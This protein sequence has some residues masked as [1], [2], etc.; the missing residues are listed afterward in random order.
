MIGMV[1]PSAGLTMQ[2]GTIW[3]VR[4]FVVGG[5]ERWTDFK[6]IKISSTKFLNSRDASIKCKGT[7]FFVWRFGDSLIFG[8]GRFHVVFCSELFRY[9]VWALYFSKAFWELGSWHSKRRLACQ[10][11][12]AASYLRPE[13]PDTIL[14]TAYGHDA[15]HRST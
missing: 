12:A 5:V 14:Y 1:E 9:L 13:D 3:R 10:Y 7:C 4:S 11:C 2:S 8:L 15:A 6:G